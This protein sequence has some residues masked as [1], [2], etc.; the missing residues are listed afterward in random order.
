MKLHYPLHCFTINL[1]H[2]EA[3]ENHLPT[4]QI[5]ERKWKKKKLLSDSHY[6]FRN[7]I[8]HYPY[9]KEQWCIRMCKLNNYLLQ[10]EILF[11]SREE[12]G[13]AV[14]APFWYGNSDLAE[15]VLSPVTGG[16]P[17]SQGVKLYFSKPD[18]IVW[19]YWGLAVFKRFC[20]QNGLQNR[21]IL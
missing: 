6:L 17:G 19:K 16:T 14:H 8:L 9:P 7:S 5:F 4:S 11:I 15:L 21:L 3:V 12:R 13:G 10:S 2:P 20:G 18:K 1:L